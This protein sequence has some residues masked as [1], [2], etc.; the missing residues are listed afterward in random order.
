MKVVTSR[1]LKTLGVLVALL[2]LFHL[3]EN[4]RG[5]RA[6]AAWK[7]SRE[8]LG[9]RFDV[10]SLLPPPVPDS[11]NFATAPW[12]A[13]RV[14]PVGQP[15]PLGPRFG[16][17]P[18]YSG[19]WQE[20]RRADLK[21]WE[22]KL[23]KKLDEVLAPQEPM[24]KELEEAS[25]RPHSR[26]A[27]DVRDGDK[28]TLLG[29]RHDFRVLRTRAQLNLWQGKPDAALKDLLT[30]LRVVQHLQGEPFLLSHLLRNGLVGILLQPVWEGLQDHRWNEAQIVQLQEA[31]GR[32]N[33]LET[34]R[35]VWMLHRHMMREPFEEISGKSFLF[36]TSQPSKLQRLAG[37]GLSLLIPK[38]WVYQN[39]FRMDQVTAR[40]GVDV[41]DPEHR[42][43][44][45]LNSSERQAPWRGP[46]T[47]MARLFDPRNFHDQNL[48]TAR[49]Q[50]A[51]DQAFLACALERHRL[52]SKDYPERLEAL[53]PT[54][55]SALPH[56]VVEGRPLVYQRLN[57]DAYRLYALGGNGKDEGGLIA[58]AD[59]YGRQDPNKGDWVWFQGR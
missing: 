46:Y 32:V 6:W 10:E 42:V 36:P 19:A 13:W 5:K 48:R 41:L 30:G 16:E 50:A 9:E 22:R 11:E 23:G 55:L 37:L 40:Q 43:L 28:L 49:M 26:L 47:L 8:A 56:D 59:G 35:R 4:W 2:A 57:R 44:H 52:A 24:L 1:S 34:Q 51:L 53:V 27:K 17:D 31:L 18:T 58:P 54:Y 45:V 38:G 12:T 39:V 33:L 29:F 14:S 25:A 3:V 21:G 20:G 15:L 7:A